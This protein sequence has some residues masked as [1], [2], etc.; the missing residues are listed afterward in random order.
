MELLVSALL[1][2][3]AAADGPRVRVKTAEATVV[4][5]LLAQDDD[6]LVVGTEDAG[7]IAVPRLAITSLEESHGRHSRGSRVLKGAGIGLA[8]GAALG[9]IIGFGSGDDTCR[10]GE[11]CLLLFDAGDKATMGAA[12]LGVIGGAVGALAGLALPRDRWERVDAPRLRLS[13]APVPRGAAA[14]LSVSF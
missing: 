3:A 5:T 8:T 4:G 13:V 1:L 14:L 12:G 10:P 9:L 7:R 11:Y 6:R 2:A